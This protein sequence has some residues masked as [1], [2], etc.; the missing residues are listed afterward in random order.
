MEGPNHAGDEL[1]NALTA[2]FNGTCRLE[3]VRKAVQACRSS[4]TTPHVPV[5]RTAD[6][7]RRLARLHD[8]NFGLEL[9]NRLKVTCTFDGSDC[10]LLL[11]A[12][13]LVMLCDDLFP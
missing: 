4:S 3:T 9:L 5:G 11:L 7:W 10:A 13:V 1:Q 6:S 2:F 8:S 12:C